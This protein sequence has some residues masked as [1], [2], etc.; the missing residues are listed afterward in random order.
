MQV[1]VSL[2][3]DEINKIAVINETI[4]VLVDIKGVIKSIDLEAGFIVMEVYDS[5]TNKYTDRR[6]YTNAETKIA[7]ADFNLQGLNSLKINQ[8]I[9]IRG[10]GT[11]EGVFAKT[12]QLM[13]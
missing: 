1:E 12:I 11:A 5:S 2:I 3:D 9:N 7:D 10:T 6:V 8:I 13:N 4:S